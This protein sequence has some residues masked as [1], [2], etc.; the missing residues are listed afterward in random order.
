MSTRTIHAFSRPLGA[1]NPELAGT[2]RPA[3]T[4]LDL[5]LHQERTATIDN[6]TRSCMSIEN[7]PDG[8]FV[9]D[10]EHD[11]YL[12]LSDRLLRWSPAGYERPISNAPLSGTSIDAGLNCSNTGCWLSGRHPCFRV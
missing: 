6:G 1:A 2:P 12:V 9:T 4:V 7:M 8:V 3:A 11:A 5:A 10:D